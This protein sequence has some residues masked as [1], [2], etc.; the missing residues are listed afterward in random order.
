MSIIIANS[1]ALHMVVEEE[2]SRL[3][4][5]HVI[6]EKEELNLLVLEEMNPK[7]IFFLHWSWIIPKEIF[8]K[9]NCVVFHMT[10]VPY[11]RGGSPLQNLILR[12]FKETK[13]S[14]LK[15]QEG[16]DSGPVFLKRGL[17]LA[18]S[19]QEIFIRAGKIM[20][21]MIKQIVD[22]NPFPI[23]QQGVGTTFK[24]RRPEESNIEANYYCDLASLYDF[25]RMLDA[26][27]YPHAF[28]ESNGF[29]FE[30]KNASFSK[31]GELTAY[32]RISEK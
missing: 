2:V 7:F 23:P 30:F 5:T 15:V 24:R 29:K 16:V 4:P 3:Y 8:D 28:I 13:I 22:E 10:D 19:A 25:I 11:G 18:G 14:A 20:G 26:P 27:G 1:N 17:S 6:H 9:Y 31:D 12:G 21:E 32:V